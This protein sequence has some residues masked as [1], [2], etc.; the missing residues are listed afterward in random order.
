MPLNVG[1]LVGDPLRRAIQAWCVECVLRP[2]TSIGAVVGAHRRKTLDVL[3][4]APASLPTAEHATEHAIRLQRSLF[5]LPIVLLVN[6]AD[7][8]LRSDTQ[9]VR[10]VAAAGWRFE[11]AIFRTDRSFL[12]LDEAIQQACTSGVGG[13]FCKLLLASCR[14][15]HSDDRTFVIEL[16]QR[17]QAFSTAD[18]TVPGLD[19]TGRDLNEVLKASGLHTFHVLRRCSRIVQCWYLMRQLRMP[20]SIACRRA[21]YGSV[22]ALER[23]VRA[24]APGSTPR[25]LFD[26]VTEGELFEIVLRHALLDACDADALHMSNLID[27]DQQLLPDLLSPPFEDGSATDDYAGAQ[28]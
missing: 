9:R 8:A 15:L 11:L 22:D 24:I 18:C 12:G 19:K 5:G 28:G 25:T 14:P 3:V 2:F 23:D 4:A 13:H 20:A 7:G 17:P 21:G 26:R 6:A 10:D 27:S 16:F 1:M